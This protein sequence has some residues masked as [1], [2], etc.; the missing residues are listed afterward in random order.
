MAR[1]MSFTMLLAGGLILAAGG[2][3]DA[4]KTEAV[5]IGQNVFTSIECKGVA[6]TPI[7]GQG[8]VGMLLNDNT[9]P[10][11][12][13]EVVK[14]TITE[15]L[16]YRDPTGRVYTVTGRANQQLDYGPA[17]GFI[18]GKVTFNLDITGPDGTKLGMYNGKTDPLTTD[19]YPLPM[20]GSC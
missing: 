3:A 7:G 12:R 13:Q 6:L 16:R 17:G 14:F 10:K 15:P 20:A 18:G 1:R 11:G 5:I 4:A 8:S 19:I 9:N 2:S